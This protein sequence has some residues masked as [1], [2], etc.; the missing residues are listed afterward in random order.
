M[1]CTLAALCLT[2]A[3]MHWAIISYRIGEPYGEGLTV[4]ALVWQESSFCE[5][6]RLRWS[7]GCLGTKRAT[8]RKLFDPAATRARLESDNGY[9]IQAGTAILLYCRENVRTWR[10]MVACYHWGLPHESTMADADIDKDP[11]TLAIAEKVKKLRAI[12]ISTE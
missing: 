12:P 1:T 3:Q 10:R 2:A 4:S 7:V 11:Y 8:V 9:S 6:K 5:F